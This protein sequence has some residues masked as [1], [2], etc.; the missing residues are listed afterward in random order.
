LEE[1][2]QSK[3]EAKKQE[4]LSAI[5]LNRKKKLLVMTEREKRARAAERRFLPIKCTQCAQ[6]ISIE[7]FEYQ[8]FQFCSI[9]CIA[10]Y[11]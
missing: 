10:Q 4:I 2:E 9:E 8:T 5:S 6:V 1:E 7:P 3:A 11:Q